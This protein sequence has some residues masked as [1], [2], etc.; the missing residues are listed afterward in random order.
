MCQVCGDHTKIF[1]PDGHSI[2]SEIGETEEGLVVADIDLSML[3]YSKAVAVPAGHYA[4]KDV[5]RLLIDREKRQAVV[6]EKDLNASKTTVPDIGWTILRNFEDY[7]TR[8]QSPLYLNNK[9]TNLM[10]LRFVVGISVGYLFV[11]LVNK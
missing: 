4:K 1:A 7:P 11:Q 2:G 8:Y 3:P 10:N 9:N 6:E 5:T